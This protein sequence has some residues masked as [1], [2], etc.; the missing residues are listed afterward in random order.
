MCPKPSLS[1]VRFGKVR[2]PRRPVH[3]DPVRAAA[4]RMKQFVTHLVRPAMIGRFVPRQ[5]RII[6]PDV[7]CDLVWVEG[8][9]MFAG[10]LTRARPTTASNRPVLLA[11]F[12]P[13]LVR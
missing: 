2:N 7:R 10:P 5:G 11:S 1:G 4:P 8:R 12:D 13:L 6:V 3:N 9:L